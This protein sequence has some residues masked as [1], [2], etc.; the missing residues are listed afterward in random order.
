MGFEGKQDLRST[1]QN[2]RAWEMKA[3][4]AK[5]GPESS[6]DG[7]DV[8]LLTKKSKKKKTTVAPANDLNNQNDEIE[9]ADPQAVQESIVTNEESIVVKDPSLIIQESGS[10]KGAMETERDEKQEALLKKKSISFLTKGLRVELDKKIS[11]TANFNV[12]GKPFRA[13]SSDVSYMASTA[14]K[15]LLENEV[16]LQEIIEKNQKKADWD[17]DDGAKKQIEEKIAKANFNSL[18]F[19]VFLYNEICKEVAKAKKAIEAG[20]LYQAA[21]VEINS[22]FVRKLVE[23]VMDYVAVTSYVERDFLE[24]RK[25][26]KTARL[27]A[28]QVGELQELIHRALTDAIGANE[29]I[30]IGLKKPA[31]NVPD[32]IPV[33]KTEEEVAY[34]GPDQDFSHMNDGQEGFIG[35][36]KIEVKEE[37]EQNFSHMG[38]DN[39]G[40]GGVEK[41]IDDVEKSGIINGEPAPVDMPVEKPKKNKFEILKAQQEIFE[42]NLIQAIHAIREIKADEVDID[43]IPT[44]KHFSGD[45]KSKMESLLNRSGFIDEES[46]GVDIEGYWKELGKLNEFAK[47]VMGL[48]K[49]GKICVSHDGNTYFIN[50]EKEI[51]LQ[52]LEKITE[53]VVGK[54]YLSAFVFGIKG[55]YDRYVATLEENPKWREITLAKQRELKEEGVAYF[56]NEILEEN[57]N[58]VNED[59]RE[60]VYK[61]IFSIINK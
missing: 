54:K 40:F 34:T 2:L 12:F 18:A 5:K 28:E 36:K 4:Q 19:K 39:E 6:D 38:E 20:Q 1:A 41:D 22:E 17:F 43:F 47:E 21:P 11:P 45:L 23:E 56:V 60:K 9:Q 58:I 7:G 55:D 37:Q 59:T 33:M 61:Y 53:S 14:G 31:T 25:K 52:E 3:R 30:K 57:G 16:F 49:A 51:P 44:E 26:N 13:G 15:S 24:Q 48:E 50:K 8:S 10:E 35:G 27:N 29:P 32:N 42:D 46:E